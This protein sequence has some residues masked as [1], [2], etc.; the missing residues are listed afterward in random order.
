MYT[1]ITKIIEGGLNGDREK[2]YNYSK[3]LADNLDNSGDKSLARKIRKII[4]NRKSGMLTLDSLSSKPVDGESRMEMVDVTYPSIDDSFLILNK[5][6]DDERTLVENHDYHL[7]ID[8]NELVFEVNNEDGK[9][10]ILNLDDDLEIVEPDFIQMISNLSNV[11]YI[12]EKKADI[13][14]I[15]FIG[16]SKVLD[17]PFMRKDRIVVEE[18]QEMPE[19][20]KETIYINKCH[21]VVGIDEWRELRKTSVKKM[22]DVLENLPKPTPGNKA[23]FIFHDPPYG[24]GLDNC[25]NGEI[26]G[27]KAIVDFLIQ[28]KAYMSFH[29]HIH[30]SPDI[31]GKWFN[32]LEKTICIQPGQ[33]EYGNEKL[34]YVLVDTDKDT[35]NLKFD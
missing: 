10:S 26:V 20:L 4:E 23:V 24:I 17:T 2:V 18:G 30:E 3:V 7:D 15:S 6:T 29:G 27:S 13:E 11:V 21:D 16:L 12:D 32:Y 14:G 31:S 35:Y 28:S 1:E 9:S 5:D 22:E 25:K 19:Q 33:T 8:T 34:H